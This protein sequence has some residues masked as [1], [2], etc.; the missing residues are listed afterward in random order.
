LNFHFVIYHSFI[1]VAFQ[2]VSSLDSG[3]GGAESAEILMPSVASELFL[4][5]LDTCSSDAYSEGSAD[6]P[7]SSVS[8][9]Y[10]VPRFTISCSGDSADQV[11]SIILTTLLA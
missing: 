6:S 2:S 5:Q 4:P 8:H 3:D 10:P 11:S 9:P 1:A 7:S